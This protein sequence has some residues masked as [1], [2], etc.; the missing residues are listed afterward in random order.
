MVASEHQALRL[1]LAIAREV[2]WSRDVPA[3]DG[4]GRE[5][6]RKWAKLTLTGGSY[7]NLTP[8]ARSEPEKF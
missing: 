6:S 1:K 2:R 5:P 7:G 8:E 3:P 4:A